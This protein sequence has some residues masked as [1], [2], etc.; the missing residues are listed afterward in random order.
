MK[1]L[2]TIFI[3]FLSVFH[4]GTAKERFLYKQ[5]SQKDGLTSTV[6]CIYKEKGGNVW[7][8]TPNGLYTFNG[9]DLKR[10]TDTL[11]SNK[12]IQR[13]EED[14]EGGLWVLTNDWLMHRKKG[15]ENFTHIT[16]KEFNGLMP[17]YCTC[18]DEEGIW[19]GC[20]GGIYRYTYE[21]DRFALFRHLDGYDSFMCLYINRIDESTLLCSSKSGANIVNIE[22]GEVSEITLGPIK[23][24]SGI[25]TDSRGRLWV[26]FYNHGIRVLDKDGTLLKSY[27]TKNSSLSN[28]VVICFTEKDSKMW[29]GTD[30]GGINIIDMETDSIRVLSRISGDSSSFPDHSIKNLYTDHDGNVWA[31]STREGLIR[32]SQSGMKTYSDSHIGLSSG[33]SDQT[34]LSLFQ[35]DDSPLIWIGTD[36]EGIN[37]FNP[38][39]NRF[40]HYEH[41]LKTKIVSM[42][43]YSETELAMTIYAD[44]AWIFDKKTGRIRPMPINDEELKYFMKYTGRSVVIANG[45]YNDIYF[46][47]REVQ[48]YDKQTGSCSTVPFASEVTVAGALY[49]IGESEKGIYLHDTYK[50]YLLDEA[51]EKVFVLGS[52]DGHMINNGCLGADGCIWL[53]TT[54][55]LCRLNEDDTEATFI[56]TSLFSEATSVVWDGKSRVWIGSGSYLYAYLVDEG[57]FALFG[58]SDGASPNEFLAK[59]RL[60]SCEGDIYMGGV[61]GLL[62]IDSDYVI[63]ASEVPVV[64]LYNISA[65]KISLAPQQNGIYEVPRYSKTLSISVSTHETDIFR[66]KM[67]RFQIQGSGKEYEQTSPSLEIQNIPNPGKYDVLVSCTKRN[68]EWTDPEKIMTIRIPAPWYLSVWF[69]IGVLMFVLIVSVSVA[70][71]LMH[72]KASRLQLALK[73]QEQTIYEEKVRMLINISHELRTPLTLIMAPLKRLLGETNSEAKE[74]ATLGRVYRQSRRMKDLLDMVLDLRK[75]EAGRNSLKLERMDFNKWLNESVED[76]VSEERQEGIDIIIDLDPRISMMDFDRRKCDTVLMNI[77]I[78]AIKHSSFGDTITIRTRLTSEDMV[79]ISVSDEGP[80]LKDTDSARMF[81]RFYQGNTE[82]YG[83]GIGLSYSKIL[84]ELHG[85]RI[86]AENNP[87]KGATFWWEIPVNSSKETMEQP[88]RAYLNELMGFN[89]G[90]DVIAPEIDSFTTAGMTLM[91]VDDNQDLLDFLREALAPEFKDILTATGGNRAMSMIRSG[92]L[93]DLIVSDVNMPDGDGFRFCNELKCDERFS[94]IPFVLLTARGEEQSQGDSYRMGADGF[95]AKP[96][97]I[98]TLMELLRGML[99]RKE[100][101]RRKYLDTSDEQVDAS[102]GSKEERFII[103]LNRI[104]SEHL[105]DPG[106]DQVLL[107]RELGM[108]RAALYNRMK[109]ITGSGAKEYITRIRL[110]KAKSLIENSGLTIAEVSDMTGFASQSYFSTAFKAY[111][112]Q[113][114]TQ[115]KK[116]LQE[117]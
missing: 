22:T 37:S 73:E 69:I 103:D 88:A 36:G 79:R 115:Y 113:S 68:G 26:A 32:I 98:E 84:V 116:S 59:P 108:S 15:E 17:F 70:I 13:I 92:Q 93:P 97:E 25:T 112:G 51:A 90:G 2:L 1:R 67:Y 99:R 4:S 66:H 14:K 40:T 44:G 65:D 46:L 39:I 6:N 83:T 58:E 7:L 86:A 49:V 47:R 16:S 24:I 75:M 82:T 105:S 8:G 43:T 31:G 106:L 33:L 110:E 100:D 48:K 80:G 72:R 109:A 91:L 62:C 95:L 78:N 60:L 21:D 12:N 114:P 57:I 10:S 117:S 30:G 54:K 63:D 9:H 101:I 55:G 96:F 64:S 102:Y 53:A 85:G 61:Q 34:V 107:C 28:D 89:P 50:V 11:F 42:A 19:F 20:F 35:E 29:A 52:A 104:I 77:L 94:H 45:K 74:Y 56:S 38:N 27:S 41:T 5:I 71:G 111:T 81:T 3:L 18:H 23:E 76:I 87:D